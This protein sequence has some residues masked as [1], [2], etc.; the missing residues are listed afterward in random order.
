MNCKGSVNV[1]KK[2]WKSMILAIVFVLAVTLGSA[3]VSPAEARTVVPLEYDLSH[4]QYQIVDT[5]GKTYNYKTRAAYEIA[6]KKFKQKWAVQQEGIKAQASDYATE[7][8]QHSGFRGWKYTTP[9]GYY[10]NFNNSSYND[11][12]SSLKTARK[13]SGTRVCFHKNGGEPCKTFGPGL[14]IRYVGDGWND[15]ISYINV[16][17]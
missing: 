13:S 6:E 3:S 7:S 8:F 2:K 17:R 16:Y 10:T 5:D 9:V 15:Q 1:M 4:V 11:E 14:D 12:V